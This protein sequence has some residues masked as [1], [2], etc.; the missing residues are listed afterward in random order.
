MLSALQESDFDNDPIHPIH[1]LIIG[2]VFCSLAKGALGVMKCSHLGKFF[3]DTFVHSSFYPM[4][5]NHIRLGFMQQKLG[6]LKY[7][8]D[9][10]MLLTLSFIQERKYSIVKTEARGDLWVYIC[11]CKAGTRRRNYLEALSSSAFPEGNC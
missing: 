7:Y 1:L 8:V 10:W 6:M 3:E 2:R 9:V 11:K 5:L 4:P